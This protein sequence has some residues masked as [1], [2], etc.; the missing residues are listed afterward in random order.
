MGVDQPGRD[1][2][3]GEVEDVD[4]GGHRA[5]GPRAGALD[6]PVADEDDGVRDRRRRRCRRRGWRRPGR[7]AAAASR[8]RRLEGGRHRDLPAR[9]GL[10]EDPLRDPGL[11]ARHRSGPGSG[12]CRR[13]PRDDRGEPQVQGVEVVG[14]ALAGAL[15]E[16]GE[17]ERSRPARCGRGSASRGSRRGRP[18]GRAGGWREVLLEQLPGGAAVSRNIR[19]SR[20]SRRGGEQGEEDPTRRLSSSSSFQLMSFAMPNAAAAASPPTNAVCNALRRRER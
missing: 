1:P 4:S 12:R 10:Q 18:R 6:P 7:A 3:A 13:R 15:R 2:A 16:P 11:L 8:R 20:E 17:A 19:R 14:P 9:R 5:G